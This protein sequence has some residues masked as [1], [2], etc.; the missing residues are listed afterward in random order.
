MELIFGEPVKDYHSSE[1]AKSAVIYGT[2][3]NCPIIDRLSADG[4]IDV[5]SVRGKE[6]EYGDAW[7]FLSNEDGITK[8]WCDGL[9]RNKPFENVIT[10]GMRG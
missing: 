1:T 10:M 3:G 4:K 6:S 9:L 2:V 8:F 5:K 7:S